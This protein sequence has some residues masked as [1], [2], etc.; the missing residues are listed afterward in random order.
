MR[1]LSCGYAKNNNNIK[2]SVLVRTVGRKQRL[3]RSER[4]LG[5]VKEVE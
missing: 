1:W 5:R 3:N 4:K 2:K